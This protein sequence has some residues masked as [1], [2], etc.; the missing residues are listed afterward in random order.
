MSFLLKGVKLL[1]LNAATLS[2]NNKGIIFRIRLRKK[3]FFCN[4]M[5]LKIITKFNFNTI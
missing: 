2:K 3:I 1:F 4:R 5:L